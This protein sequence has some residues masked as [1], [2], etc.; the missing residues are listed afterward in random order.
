M[1]EADDIDKVDPESVNFTEV[2]FRTPVVTGSIN[3]SRSIEL[4]HRPVHSLKS[5][6]CH[7]Q[8]KTHSDS[9]LVIN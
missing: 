2:F 1:S 9:L 6:F 8:A 4:T 5:D 3:R 7:S